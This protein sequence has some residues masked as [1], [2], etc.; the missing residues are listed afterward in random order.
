MN[1]DDYNK[2]IINTVFICVYD[3]TVLLLCVIM[4]LLYYDLFHIQMPYQYCRIN[5]T[6]IG[7]CLYVL[8]HNGNLII[9]HFIHVRKSKS[10]PLITT[11][12][13]AY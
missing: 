12:A 7:L 11:Y 9:T 10:K 4:L 3:C 5:E 2:R 8:R 1:I 6:Y 13:I